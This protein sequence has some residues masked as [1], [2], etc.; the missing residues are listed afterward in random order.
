M[1]LGADRVHGTL[2]PCHTHEIWRVF[3]RHPLPMIQPSGTVQSSTSGEVQANPLVSLH[4]QIEVGYPFVSA[5]YTLRTRDEVPSGAFFLFGSKGFNEAMR[6]SE[7]ND[8]TAIG[9][10][11][12][13]V[14]FHPPFTQVET[15]LKLVVLSDAW[16]ERTAPQLRRF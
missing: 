3:W 13:R 11:T 2:L 10:R 9:L 12:P 15:D 8:L 4:R 16:R 14:S 7:T 6:L 1:N 5:T